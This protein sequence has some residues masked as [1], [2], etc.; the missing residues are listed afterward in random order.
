MP[1]WLQ[2][3]LALLV[4]FIGFWIAYRQYRTAREKLRLDLF[5]KRYDVFVQAEKFVQNVLHTGLPEHNHFGQ[6]WEARGKARFLFGEDVEIALKDIH[7]LAA[8][9][10]ALRQTIDDRENVERNAVVNRITEIESDLQKKY[11][12]LPDVFSSYLRFKN[13][14]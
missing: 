7:E 2:I 4:P 14:T 9:L 11:E 13:K 6:L 8:K 5:D 10:R 12:V 3:F 1:I